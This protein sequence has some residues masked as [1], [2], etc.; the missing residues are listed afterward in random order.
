MGTQN[1]MSFV[2]Y[3]PYFTFSCSVVHEYHFVTTG[4]TIFITTDSQIG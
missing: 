2:V 1:R 4:Y 3:K